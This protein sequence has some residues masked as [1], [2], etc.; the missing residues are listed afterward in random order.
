MEIKEYL[1]NMTKEAIEHIRSQYKSKNVFYDEPTEECFEHS[2]EEYRKMQEEKSYDVCEETLVEQ[3][4][5][6]EEYYKIQQEK[7]FFGENPIANNVIKAGTYSYIPKELSYEEKVNMHLE[8][9]RVN[10]VKPN[11]VQQ[12]LKKNNLQKEIDRTVRETEECR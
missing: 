6:C 12:I 2:K 11:D 4:E 1:A 8:Q 5:R 9:E 7:E 3:A 10:E